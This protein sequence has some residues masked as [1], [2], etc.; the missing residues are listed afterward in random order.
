MVIAGYWE[1]NGF[2]ARVDGPSL[3]SQYAGL[4]ELNLL[5]TQKFFCTPS[6]TPVPTVNAK[7]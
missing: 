6:N 5:V 1:L 3:Q 7:M 4:M 2:S